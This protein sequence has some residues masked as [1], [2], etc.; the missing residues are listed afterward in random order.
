[1]T[2]R[3]ESDDNYIGD[4]AR[5]GWERLAVAK[6]L[7]PTT[8]QRATMRHLSRKNGTIMGIANTYNRIIRRELETHAA[9]F[10]ITNTFALGDFGV[11][12]GGIFTRIGNISS[13][14]IKEWKEKSGPASKINFSSSSVTAV[15]VEAGGEVDV[16][17]GGSVAAQLKF[18]FK[19][20]GAVVLKAA[21]ITSLE[22][23]ETFIVAE[24]LHRNPSWRKHY[25]FVN[26]VYVAQ[27]P[28]ILASRKKDTEVTLTGDAKALEAIDLGDLN[29]N[30]GVSA[31]SQ[32][33]LE[34]NGRSGTI[35]LG[36][37][38]VKSVG[39]STRAIGHAGSHVE[40][41]EDT[42]WD[43]EPEDDI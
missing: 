7:M 25:R 42:D 18:R 29:V 27:N 10:P 30:V 8:P 14:G 43:D 12:D 33:A 37:A 9:W 6:E 36:L 15:R 20:K 3:S 1:M 24:A 21:A 17:S 35:G 11:V 31:D 40:I 4:L 32:L 26:R 5:T 23:D 13:L 38:R 39:K 41:E 19:R 22:I 34:I 16:F 28:L 2:E